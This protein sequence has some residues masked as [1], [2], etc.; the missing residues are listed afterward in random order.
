M[1]WHRPIPYILFLFFHSFPNEFVS[2]KH[3][4][5]SLFF[6]LFFRLLNLRGGGRPPP[7]PP[8]AMPFVPQ[9]IAAS[10]VSKCIK[11]SRFMLVNIHDCLYSLD[12]INCIVI[13]TSLYLVRITGLAL[14]HKIKS[15]PG[16]AKD[17][18]FNTG[19]AISHL[20]MSVFISFQFIINYFHL[21]R[22]LSLF[23]VIQLL[24]LVSSADWSK[25]HHVTQGIFCN[26][27]WWRFAG[28]YSIEPT[29]HYL[30]ARVLWILYCKLGLRVQN[31][32]PY[33]HAHS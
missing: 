30:R 31:P 3:F 15:L 21:W 9:W 6:S 20:S 26:D 1:Y 24:Q 10:V 2:G 4:P 13:V 11:N 5:F 32:H 8:L 14:V 28:H 12:G 19:G 29:G 33:P 22:I 25:V 23:F 18:H 17:G 27:R 7:S 16:S